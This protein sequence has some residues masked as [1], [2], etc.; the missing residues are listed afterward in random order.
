MEKG[1]GFDFAIQ[2]GGFPLKEIMRQLADWIEDKVQSIEEGK[3]ETFHREGNFKLLNL[4]PAHFDI[5]VEISG[6]STQG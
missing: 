2:V 1:F 5:K 6:L 3:T 4:P